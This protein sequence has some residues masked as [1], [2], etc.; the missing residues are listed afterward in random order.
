MTVID[1][2]SDLWYINGDDKFP[3]MLYSRHKKTKFFCVGYKN[4]GE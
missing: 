4:D 1:T 2:I 3:K